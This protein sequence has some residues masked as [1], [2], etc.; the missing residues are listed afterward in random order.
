[1][2]VNKGGFI[3]LLKNSAVLSFL[4]IISMIFALRCD[5]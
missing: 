2:K 5:G 1:M 3:M 4:S